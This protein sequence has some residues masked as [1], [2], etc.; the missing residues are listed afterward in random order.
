M[1]FHY[2]F[3]KMAPVAGLA[4]CCLLVVS[5]Q[6]AAMQFA[7]YQPVPMDDEEPN[8]GAQLPHDATRSE[9]D[10][11]NVH[12]RVNPGMAWPGS[13]ALVTASRESPSSPPSFYEP[14]PALPH[15]PSAE[16][17]VDDPEHKETG[18]AGAGFGAAC[19]PSERC[20]S[21]LGLAC[22]QAEHEEYRCGCGQETP[23]FINE[24]GVKK[25]VRAKSMYESCVSHRECSFQNPNLQCVDFLCY[26]PLPYVLTEAHKCLA[27]SGPHNNMM[28]AIAP[29]AVLIAVLLLIGG[30]QAL[31]HSCGARFIRRVSGG[32]SAWSTNSSVVGLRSADERRRSESTR[33]VS[34]AIRLGRKAEASRRLRLSLDEHGAAL[35]DAKAGPRH[36]PRFIKSKPRQQSVQRTQRSRSPD[37]RAKVIKEE[38]TSYRTSPRRAGTASCKP[39]N[40][41]RILP[42]REEVAVHIFHQ[43]PPSASQEL[44]TEVP[45]LRQAQKEAGRRASPTHLLLP[46]NDP[47]C[48]MLNEAEVK[49]SVEKHSSTASDISKAARPPPRFTR[50]HRNTGSQPS[51]PF[52]GKL[53]EAASKAESTTDDSFMREIRFQMRASSV[54][55]VSVQERAMST[56]VVRTADTAVQLDK[57][58]PEMTD[59]SQ[60]M[61]EQPNL[62]PELRAASHVHKLVQEANSK[63]KSANVSQQRAKEIVEHPCGS[64]Q[65]SVKDG[66]VEKPQMSDASSSRESEERNKIPGKR[67]SFLKRIFSDSSSS[68]THG[69]APKGPPPMPGPAKKIFEQPPKEAHAS[70]VMKSVKPA[71]DS[72]RDTGNVDV[73]AP[74]PR[75]G[76][77]ATNTSKEPTTKNPDFKDVLQELVKHYAERMAS[78]ASAADV[79]CNEVAEGTSSRFS[80]AGLTVPDTS[81]PL[82]PKSKTDVPPKGVVKQSPF[83]LKELETIK[84]PSPPMS[85]RFYTTTMEESDM[86][87]PTVKGIVE[88]RESRRAVSITRTEDFRRGI[89]P[90]D[91][92]PAGPPKFTTT[93]IDEETKV[94]PVKGILHPHT[95]RSDVLRGEQRV[96]P[97]PAARPPSSS[98]LITTVGNKPFKVCAWG[99]S[100]SMTEETPSIES[101]IDGY[102]PPS[103]PPAQT[104]SLR[105]E[106][107]AANAAA[108]LSLE[109]TFRAPRMD[110]N[111]SLVTPEAV[112]GSMDVESSE[113]SMGGLRAT[114]KQSVDVASRMIVPCEDYTLLVP[115]LKDKKV[116]GNERQKKV[117]FQEKPFADVLAEIEGD[118]EAFVNKA[119]FRKGEFVV[120]VDNDSVAEGSVGNSASENDEEG[121]DHAFIESRAEAAEDRGM[122]HKGHMKLGKQEI[123]EIEGD[124]RLPL[125][126]E[127]ASQN[128]TRLAIEQI[129]GQNNQMLPDR[130]LDK[131]TASTRQLSMT[132]SQTVSSRNT[133]VSHPFCH[134]DEGPLLPS[135]STTLSFLSSDSNVSVGHRATDLTCLH[136]L[137]ELAAP[138]QETG[139][140]KS[141]TGVANLPVTLKPESPAPQELH[142]RQIEPQLHPPRQ[143]QAGEQPQNQRHQGKPT[144]SP[145]QSPSGEDRSLRSSRRCRMLQQAR[146]QDSVEPRSTRLPKRPNTGERQRLGRFAAKERR[147]GDDILR[148]IMMGNKHYLRERSQSSPRPRSASITGGAALFDETQYISQQI[149]QAHASIN[150]ADHTCPSP[151]L[152]EAAVS[153]PIAATLEAA[154]AAPTRSRDTSASVVKG[155]LLPWSEQRTSSPSSSPCRVLQWSSSRTRSRR[156][157]FL[158]S[159]DPLGARQHVTW[160]PSGEQR[161]MDTIAEAVCEIEL[162]DPQAVVGAL[163]SKTLE[164]KTGGDVF[165]GD[166]VAKS[167]VQVVVVE[168]NTDHLAPSLTSELGADSRLTPTWPPWDV[169]ERDLMA[170]VKMLSAAVGTPESFAKTIELPSPEDLLMS[171]TS[172]LASRVD[173][174][175]PSSIGCSVVLEPSPSAL[176]CTTGS[177]KNVRSRRLSAKILEGP[178]FESIYNSI[179]QPGSSPP[180]S[181]SI[182]VLGSRDFPGFLIPRGRPTGSTSEQP[183]LPGRAGDSTICG[184]S[185]DAAATTSGPVNFAS[186]LATQERSGSYHVQARRRAETTTAAG[187]QRTSGVAPPSGE[188]RPR[189]SSRQSGCRRRASRTPSSGTLPQQDAPAAWPEDSAP[190]VVAPGSEG[191]PIGADVDSEEDHSSFFSFEESASETSLLPD[192]ANLD[193]WTSTRA[194]RSRT[195]LP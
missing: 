132:P 95:V 10:D 131:L 82:S 115:A 9:W 77:A 36:P 145:S 49:V 60:Q 33:R 182:P 29:T 26:C 183:V 104:L 112:L 117:N 40:V 57:A 161:K 162:K 4:V 72:K 179:L 180:L 127:A 129:G 126:Q 134:S 169:C 114:F 149:E 133:V 15:D 159:P 79:P 14:S 35:R 166:T 122:E 113:T 160:G 165:S 188:P 51:G 193:W 123:G 63:Q 167:P 18:T 111:W 85:P 27:P 187:Q 103:S 87:C 136:T 75:K 189:S 45:W 64:R 42:V 156:P 96:G 53:R 58:S 100:F 59:K 139:D 38:S 62:A 105:Q 153:S 143:Y 191:G 90:A 34:S 173:T 119:T 124:T 78:R 30:A 94:R 99:D 144:P 164:L 21:S 41:H 194:S 56:D 186:S 163:A 116:K 101:R 118:Y 120:H 70:Q 44:S 86:L 102:L 69:S 155:A 195:D 2:G 175:A 130:N 148:V 157:S 54:P 184:S 178:C 92:T 177:S 6:S 146:R 108:G 185:T 140:G 176:S 43:S 125:K 23:V 20:S 76:G 83:F 168:D 158:S 50:Y 181:L 137:A 39:T 154:A 11:E 110:A 171:E 141:Q 147:W 97:N 7:V 74:I 1:L 31:S 88:A 52:P 150:N 47:L 8:N 142:H 172:T 24:G 135:A 22:L 28:F 5:S 71:E 190:E 128:T 107:E 32:T 93:T 67:L 138:F 65:V 98:Q 152:R 174:V 106:L 91:R 151:V 48:R 13:H 80:G 61:S 17:G 68:K 37:V 66:K 192:S 46:R 81:A 12:G 19:G 170:S 55:A 84:S 16:A 121:T 73:K 89:A 25:C 3:A 109:Q